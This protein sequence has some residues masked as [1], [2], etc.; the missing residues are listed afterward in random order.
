[1]PPSRQHEL[2]AWAVPRLR[3]ARDLDTVEAERDRLE[4]WH[5]R[6]DRSLPTRVV[7]GFHRRFAVVVETLTGPRGEFP[8][9]V[10]TPRGIDP[11]RTVVLRHGGGFM[12]PLDPFQVRYATRLADGAAGAGGAARLPAG[13]RAQLA[14]LA[15][16]A[17][18]PGRPLGREARRSGAGR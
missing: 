14:R 12:A 4:R 10:V 7:P 13:A 2:I 8:A 5:D 3:K 1:M 16:A 15:R 17:G 18:G 9:Y 6:L 11:E